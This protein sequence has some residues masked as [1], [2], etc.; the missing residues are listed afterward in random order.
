[1][2]IR[3][4]GLTDVEQSVLRELC[5]PRYSPGSGQLRLTAEKFPNRME[6]KK[7]ATYLLEKLVA[8]AKRIASIAHEYAEPASAK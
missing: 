4:L 8:E 3:D 5:G 2:N 1:M 7:Y 6:N